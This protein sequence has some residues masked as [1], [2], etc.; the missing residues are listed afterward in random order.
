MPLPALSWRKSRRQRWLNK[1]RARG[2]LRPQPVVAI[3]V[4]C[5]SISTGPD[6]AANILRRAAN[7][8]TQDGLPVD[9]ILG[10]EC[11]DFDGAKILPHFDVLHNAA[12][13]DRDGCLLAVRKT[14]GRLDSPAY[15]FA[16]PALRGAMRDRYLAV[17][18]VT[19]DPGTRYR[20]SPKVAA[21]HA[22]P[23]RGWIRWPGYMRRLAQQRADLAG[24]D[25]NKLARAVEPALRRRVRAAHILGLAVRYWIPSTRAVP[26]DVGGDHLAVAVVLWPPVE[27]KH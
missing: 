17:A 12:D 14:R 27:R 8:R 3:V 4:N 1:R 16:A 18:T 26:V 2:L 15:V 10:S 13:P 9:L 6:H 21:G 22:P 11:D 23:K 7:W 25:F 20:W 5:M 24:G 19:I